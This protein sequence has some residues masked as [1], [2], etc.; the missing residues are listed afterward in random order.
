LVFDFNSNARA[1]HAVGKIAVQFAVIAR[2]L[3]D[4]DQ[5]SAASSRANLA[6]FQESSSMDLHR[7]ERLI[8]DLLLTEA[9]P[10]D[11]IGV[12]LQGTDAHL[13]FRSW[14]KRRI[15]IAFPCATDP[16]ALRELMRR[17]LEAEC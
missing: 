1:F 15:E 9:F 3:S 2:T 10:F 5:M 14:S 7:I 16:W 13:V 11:L 8:R 6:A 17:R 4:R 12:G